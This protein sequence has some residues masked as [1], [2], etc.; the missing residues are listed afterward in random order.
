MRTFFLH[1]LTAAI[2][3]TVLFMGVLGF[4]FFLPFGCIYLFWNN[5]IAQHTA[6]PPIGFWQTSLLYAAFACIFYLSGIVRIEIKT[7][8]L[9]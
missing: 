4:L 5:V 9:D 7:E 3:C 8:N 2:I 6:L 1:P